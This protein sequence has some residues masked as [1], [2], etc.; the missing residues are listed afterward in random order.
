MSNTNPSQKAVVECQH[1][2]E[3]IEAKKT[4]SGRWILMPIGGGSG[5]SLGHLLGMTNGIVGTLK[6]MRAST[7][8]GPAGLIIGAMAG[9]IVGDH[10]DG[11]QCPSCGERINI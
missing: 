3:R 11:Y 5:G 7:L 1:C 6:P 4:S 10:L 2:N 8:F 9:Y